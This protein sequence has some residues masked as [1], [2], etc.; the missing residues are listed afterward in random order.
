MQAAEA[1]FDAGGRH[2]GAGALVIPN[3]NVAQLDPALRALGL[4]G[5]AMAS[6]P[7]VKTHDLDVPRIGYVHSWGST[8]DEGWVRAALDHYGVPYDLLRRAEAQG[9][10][11]ARQV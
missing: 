9:R 7:T 4:S 5:V 2:F 10:Q 3:A 8:Q 6:L 11:S 1:G